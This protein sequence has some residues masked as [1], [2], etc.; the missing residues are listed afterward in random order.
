MPSI[1]LTTVLI[2]TVVITKC[3]SQ[4]QCILWHDSFQPDVC[5]S[6]SITTDREQCP[7]DTP[8]PTP[9]HPELPFVVKS[10]FEDPF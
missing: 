2:N 1:D 9:I 10:A 7:L 3:R 4:K 8:S 5:N 6:L